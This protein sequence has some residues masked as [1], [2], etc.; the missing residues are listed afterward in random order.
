MNQFTIYLFNMIFLFVIGCEDYRSCQITMN[1]A[2]ANR[3]ELEDLLYHYREIDPNREKF[4][5]A[6]FLIENLSAHQSSETHDSFRT[7]QFR[8]CFQRQQALLCT[9]S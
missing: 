6:V 5:A 7:P 2:G 3:K 1:A 9:H 8:P 4:C